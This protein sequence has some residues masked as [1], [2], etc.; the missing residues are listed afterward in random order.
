MRKWLLIWCCVLLCV[1]APASVQG[2]GRYERKE[3]TLEP[4]T[5]QHIR[6]EL[7]DREIQVTD[8]PN[9][10]MHVIF[11]EN[12]K[13]YYDLTYPAK[14]T[15]EIQWV[16][17]KSWLDYIGGKAPE[18]ARTVI[19]QVPQ[20]SLE[21]L[22]LSTT[23]GDIVM[24]NTAITRSITL[25]SNGGNIL[26]ENLYPAQEISLTTKNG[27]VT[28]TINAGYDDYR[29]NAETKKGECNLPQEKSRGEKQLT[30]CCNHGDV[31]LQLIAE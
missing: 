25:E 23:N 27:N 20:T 28:G 14:D 31:E 3:Y 4:G 21:T 5:V 16:S 30:V 6:M 22:Q 24:G 7:R 9:E 17:N 8:S 11:Y 18:H 2:E 1:A 12:T 29:I 15:L 26:L 10:Q 19:L 13:E